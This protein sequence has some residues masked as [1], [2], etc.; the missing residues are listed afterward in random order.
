MPKINF[1]PFPSLT[2]ERLTLRQLKDTDDFAI[3]SLRSDASVNKYIDRPTSTTIN[4]AKQFIIK[5]HD[6][7]KQNKSI[8]W[9]VCLQDDPSLIGTICLW[10]FSNDKACAELGYEL[11]PS[12]QGKGLMDEALKSVINYSFHAL[13]LNTI[14]AY[15]HKDNV[16]STRMLVKNKFKHAPDR[17]DLDNSN[18]LIYYLNNTNHIKNPVLTKP[19][20]H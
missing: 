6:G 1:T 5:I 13:G 4:E 10:N 14:E 3:F 18:N 19:K 9:V 11:N 8:Y 7:I 17:I 15:T 16:G 2:T 20:L 12:S